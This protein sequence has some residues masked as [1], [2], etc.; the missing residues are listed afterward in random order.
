MEDNVLKTT[1]ENFWWIIVTPVGF[2]F[3]GRSVESITGR[4]AKKLEARVEGIE[5]QLS[6]PATKRWGDN[7]R[8][9]RK[10]E[11]TGQGP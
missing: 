10:V 6:Q 11:S 8:A 3:G 4:W 2:Y 7:S 9:H 1:L 5:T